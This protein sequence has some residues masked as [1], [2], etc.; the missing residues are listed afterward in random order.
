MTDNDSQTPYCPTCF[1]V[2]P[3]LAGERIKQGMA[4]SGKKPGRASVFTQKQTE[5][6]IH[7]YHT[8]RLSIGALARKHGTY[9]SMIQRILDKLSPE[10]K[11]DRPAPP[12]PP[13]KRPRKLVKRMAAIARK[14]EEEERRI[15][16]EQKLLKKKMRQ[17]A[18]ID[19]LS[20]FI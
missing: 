8:T 6:V 13:E 7:D 20:E 5:A 3:H 17:T 15:Y 10:E 12:P 1:R 19:P 2:W 4:K 9:R 18:N 11:Q 14:E 16:Q